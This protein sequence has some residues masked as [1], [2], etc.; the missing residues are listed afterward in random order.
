MTANT[1]RVL[2]DFKPSLREDEILERLAIQYRKL[3]WDMIDCALAERSLPIALGDLLDPDARTD[4]DPL[5]RFEHFQPQLTKTVLRHLIMAVRTVRPPVGA[6]DREFAA[7]PHTTA[8]LMKLIEL[9]LDPTAPVENKMRRRSRRLARALAPQAS[10]DHLKRSSYKEGLEHL[11]KGADIR[12]PSTEH[13]ADVF[14]DYVH[15]RAPWMARATEHV[16][17]QMRQ[18]IRNGRPGL[19]F[20]PLLLAGPPGTGKSTWARLVAEA[21]GTADR[22]IEVG[23]GT[24]AFRIAGLEKGWSDATPGVPVETMIDARVA[25]PLMIVDEIDKAGEGSVGTN[26]GR[27]SL[28]DALLSL[29]EPTSNR[30][31]ACPTLRVVFD[32]SHVCWVMT[33]N[34][35]NH[36]SQPLL[37]RCRVVEVEPLGL[38]A[39]M[40][41]T[42]TAAASHLDEEMV[43]QLCELVQQKWRRG[44]RMNLRTA[45]RLI[46]RVAAELAKPRLH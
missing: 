22:I 38:D 17:L 7:G 1:V 12:G 37:N 6:T 30:R 34:D 32:M 9:R 35:V 5:W 20:S 26:G 43:E 19:S 13:E 4:S 23:S 15:R 10:L 45:H 42:R 14:A 28:S 8:K 18:A 40:A 24:A 2:P 36:M 11:S 46:E 41:F 27:T 31:W 29:L 33:A 16:W 3:R 44:H 39:I 25:N 21:A